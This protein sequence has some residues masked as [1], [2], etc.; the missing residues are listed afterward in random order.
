MVGDDKA[1]LARVGTLAVAV[2]LLGLVVDKCAAP[3]AGSALAV[4]IARVLGRATDTRGGERGNVGAVVGDV[5]VVRLFDDRLLG[6]GGLGLLERRALREGAVVR[7]SSA[8][9]SSERTSSEPSERISRPAHL[10]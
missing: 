5:A 8:W 2:A 4:R 9:V 3:G 1:V 7:A 6:C 10:G